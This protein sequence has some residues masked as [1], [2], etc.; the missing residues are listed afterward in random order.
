MKNS[1]GLLSLTLVGKFVLAELI[2][3]F[4]FLSTQSDQ[5]KSIFVLQPDNEEYIPVPP[6]NKE[7]YTW[8]HSDNYLFF[9][10]EYGIERIIGQKYPNN[11][12]AYDGQLSYKEIVAVFSYIKSK[13]SERIQRSHEQINKQSKHG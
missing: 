10:R 5:E 8:H 6:H 7:G 13:W 3:S 12:P 4:W 9:I 11:M 2:P 1:S